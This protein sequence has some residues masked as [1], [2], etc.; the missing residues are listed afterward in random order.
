MWECELGHTW[1]SAPSNA[2]RRWCPICSTGVSERV[3]K[4]I[5]ETIFEQEFRKNRPPWLINIDG[6]QMHLDGF[7]EEIGVGFEFHGRQHF[8]K[9]ADNLYHRSSASLLKRIADDKRKL[10]LCENNNVVLIEVPYHLNQSKYKETTYIQDME[11]YVLD[12]KDC[13]V[14]QCK[15]RNFD[16]RIPGNGIILDAIKDVYSPKFLKKMQE[17]AKAQGGEC[18]SEK[19]YNAHTKYD[20]S[21]KKNHPFL[22]SYANVRAGH[23]CPKCQ[24]KAKLT[25]EDMQELAA[26]REEGGKC[27]SDKYVNNKT[28][29]LWQCKEGHKWEATPSSVKGGSWCPDSKCRGKRIWETRRKNEIRK[30]AK[31]NISIKSFSP[32]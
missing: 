17:Y 30:I 11:T 2:K 13:I 12:M 28:N 9:K 15:E 31:D 4:K 8:M 14:Q 3:C 27:L 18:R 32:N 16:I 22:M 5:F 7:S 1:E 24:G 23:W 29:L 6:K 26:R 19:Y 25:I 20:F 10:E 21:C